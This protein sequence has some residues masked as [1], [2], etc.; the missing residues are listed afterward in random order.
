MGRS[1]NPLRLAGVILIVAAGL[2]GYRK[3]RR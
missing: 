2:A 3:R 1:T